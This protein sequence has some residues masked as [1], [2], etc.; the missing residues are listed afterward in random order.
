MEIF[1]GMFA[2]SFRCF[3]TQELPVH[4]KNGNTEVL[5]LST[6]LIVHVNGFIIPRVYNLAWE[7]KTMLMHVINMR[8]CTEIKQTFQKAIEFNKHC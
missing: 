1:P 3:S 7:G 4:G 8:A 5:F 2:E 6:V